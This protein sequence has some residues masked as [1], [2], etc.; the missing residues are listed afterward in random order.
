MLGDDEIKQMQEEIDLLEAQLKE[1][2]HDLHKARYANLRKAVQARKDAE[3]E[4]MAELSKLGVKS[5]KG[6]WGF[7]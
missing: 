4:V 2:R 3:E 7:P 5:F 1:R 6:S